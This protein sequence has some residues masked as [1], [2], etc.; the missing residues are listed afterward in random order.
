MTP[1]I[2][3]FDADGLHL[4]QAVLLAGY[5]YFGNVSWNLNCMELRAEPCYFGVL[6]ARF[7]GH[8]FL[9]MKLDRELEYEKFG[10]RNNIFE[11]E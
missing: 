3:K 2:L 6:K 10:F 11:S 7:D 5:F 9:H 8:A 4:S 1:P